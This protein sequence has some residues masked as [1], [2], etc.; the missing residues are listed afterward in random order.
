M[1]I[2]KKAVF[3]WSGGKDSALAL[4]Y[5]L[6]EDKYEILSLL[7]TVNRDNSRSS[8]H[9]I[10]TT[11]LQKQAESI[12]LPLYI[13][14][15]TP[16]GSMDDYTEAM[17][18]A[19]NHFKSLDVESFIFG[20]IFLHDV[21][22]YREM[23]LEPYGIEVVEP[24]WDKSSEIVMAEFLSSGLKTVVVT[25]T[26][27]ILD[28][29]FIGREID[30]IFVKD[31]PSEVDVCGENGEYHT[32]CYSGGMFRTPVPFFLGEPLRE[33][34]SVKLDDGTTKD[35]TYCFANLQ[36]VDSL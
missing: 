5:I 28:E 17:S 21:R 12:G 23:Q 4:Y 36:D 9:D 10:P 25:T 20:D 16:K 11:L 2:K 27:D 8:M 33:T 30:G 32:F 35:Y 15:L 24:L 13:V 26:A 18:I 14:D 34:Y 3:N 6:Q 7:T 29:K 19:V 22:S 1:M 31:L